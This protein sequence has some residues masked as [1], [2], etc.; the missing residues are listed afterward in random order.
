MRKDWEDEILEKLK[1]LD[2]SK[3]VIYAGDMNVAHEEIGKLFSQI[4]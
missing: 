1:A 4:F 3:P 2:K